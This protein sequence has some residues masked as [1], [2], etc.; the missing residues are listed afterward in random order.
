MLDLGVLVL[1]CLIGAIWLFG[2]DALGA[3]QWLPAGSGAQAAKWL[4]WLGLVLVLQTL[5]AWRRWQEIDTLQ[6]VAET[7][8]L[9]GVHNRRKIESLLSHEFD[10]ALRYGRPLSIVML[11]VDHF[12]QVNDTHGH[13][14]GD[15]VLA[16][17]ARRIRRRMRL[18][19]H[20]GRW[21][22]EEFLLICP[23]TDT[24]DAMLVADRMRRTISQR[25]VHKAGIVTASFGVSSYA[26][27]G[28]YGVL[29]DEADSY[30]YIA[31]HQGRD[32]VI[33]RM[34]VMVQSRMRS[35]GM[36]MDEP[37]FAG[38]PGASPLSTMLST[39][40]AP[41]RRKTRKL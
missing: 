26:G 7:D 12:K 16:A 32:R 2:L 27:Q 11:D 34:I 38:M 24:T 17:I 29:V 19:D 35:E 25:P 23:E 6:A 3:R 18:S 8:V 31:K 37:D 30:L 33:S 14:V 36:P 40:V 28:D 9:T 20:F 1:A 4:I 39:I 10:R 22:G 15:M 5:F 41:L 21:G 13:A